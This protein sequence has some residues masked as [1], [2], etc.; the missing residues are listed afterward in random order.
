MKDEI[1]KILDIENYRNKDGYV[2]NIKLLPSEIHK[3][4]DYITNLQEE[5][6]KFK[7]RCEKAN[8]YIKENKD[9]YYHDWGEDDG[10]YDTYLDESEIDK[11]SNILNGGDEE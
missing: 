9:K 5:K 7:S 6:D 2:E 11:L 1:K 3:L 8:E 10:S 4:S